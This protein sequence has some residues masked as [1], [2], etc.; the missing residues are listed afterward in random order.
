MRRDGFR[1]REAKASGRTGHLVVG[2]HA[3]QIYGREG[4]RVFGIVAG[5]RLRNGLRTLDEEQF[6]PAGGWSDGRLAGS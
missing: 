2:R 1:E 6:W 4:V 3:V 5:N